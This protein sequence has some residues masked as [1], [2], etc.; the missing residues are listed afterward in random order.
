MELKKRIGVW[1]AATLFCFAMQCKTV[2]DM[3]SAMPEA[4]VF[5]STSGMGVSVKQ[6]ETAF[7]RAAAVGEQ[8]GAIAFLP[9]MQETEGRLL[10]ATSNYAAAV[11]MRFCAGG[12]FGPD[13]VLQHRAFAVIPD[14]LALD[15]LG[16]DQVVGAELLIQGEYYQV[17][18]IYRTDRRFLPKICTGELPRVYV[19]RSPGR[20]GAEE[21]LATELL[22]WSEK[23]STLEQLRE[24]AQSA[25]GSV[26]SG[27]VQDLRC[28]RQFA[29]QLCLF[30]VIGA[31]AW[32]LLR[33]V[34]R[35][36][37]ALIGFCRQQDK[38]PRRAAC[39]IGCA[40]WGLAGPLVAVWGVSR[41]VRLPQSWLPSEQLF[42]WKWYLE[43]ILTFYQA[44]FSD[45]QQYRA[46]TGCYLPLIAAWGMAALLCCLAMEQWLF[47]TFSRKQNML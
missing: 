45:P 47:Y 34:N 10:T 35:G 17:C 37:E 20:D 4:V 28:A 9:S 32:P 30:T 3:R 11:G 8:T 14:T 18:G 27:R 38:T 21:A 16:S 31:G 7:D 25:A 13:A 1:L 40:L 33:W 42:D 5:S 26:L 43:R 12:W 44:L 2:R 15:L 24:T 6:V 23:E 39:Q 29:V 19:S 46:L 36:I 22:I 41:L